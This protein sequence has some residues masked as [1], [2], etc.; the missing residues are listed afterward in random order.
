MI[1]YMLGDPAR[2]RYFYGRARELG[3]ALEQ[4]WTWV[5]GQRRIGKSS[6]LL[7]VQ[8]KERERG[9]AVPLYLDLSLVNPKKASGAELFNVL[10]RLHLRGETKLKDLGI[11]PDEFK[12]FEPAECFRLLVER[13]GEQ[14]GGV[15][16][17]WDEAERLIDVEERDPG[18]LDALRGHLQGLTGFRFAIAGTQLLSQLFGA[19]NHAS[20]FIA[21]F[22]W[23]PL[24]GL[25]EADARALFR[26]EHADGWL[27]PLPEEVVSAALQWSGGHPLMLQELGARL[28]HA[29]DH[30]GAAAGREVH[31]QCL[32]ELGADPRLERI[33]HDDYARFNKTQRAILDLLCDS[34]GGVARADLSAKIGDTRAGCEDALGFLSSYGYAFAGPTVRLRYEFY[35][36]FRPASPSG[37]GPSAELVN[38]IAEPTVFLSYSERD[39]A[40]ASFLR[41]LLLAQAK[42]SRI[43]VWDQSRI[44][45]GQDRQEQLRR[46]LSRATVAVLL[47]SSDFLASPSIAEVEL[48]SIEAERAAKRCEV[49]CVYVRAVADPLDPGGPLAKYRPL[50]GDALPLHSAK[51]H[52]DE[53]MAS[54][55]RAIINAAVRAAAWRRVPEG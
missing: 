31:E 37:E 54:C 19:D 44:E 35:R 28:Y 38:R 30:H 34:P 10:L 9:A 15:V 2:D 18:F 16:F 13:I 51:A 4:G 5:C 17:L 22:S 14:R 29:T 39:A 47:V 24:G 50:N 43:D 53:V 11:T 48:P 12:G 33:V 36:R 45:P 1:P 41:T 27:D 7:R 42:G 49:L 46:A 55:A 6:L 3:A 23:L 26:G 8:D 20:S 21:T 25:A 32:F 52:G 40:D